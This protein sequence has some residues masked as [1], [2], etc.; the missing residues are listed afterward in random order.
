LPAGD[1]ADA[2]VI[3]TDDPWAAVAVRTAD[4]VPLLLSDARTGM[5]AAAHAGWKGLVLRVPAVTVQTL[6]DQF[7]SRPS[8]LVA[9]IGPSIGA[10]CYEIGGEVREQFGAARFSGAELSR[11]FSAE[12][13]R[14]P[15][16]PAFTNSL[17]GRR[18]HWFLDI[19]AVA[20]DQ[21]IAE[22]V[23]PDRIHVA[24]LCTASH[25]TAFCSYRRDGSRAGRLAAAI[26]RR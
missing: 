25:A 15:L 22:G 13:R 16:N 5:V 4:C 23:S 6:C 2:D 9:A 3:V 14:L 26:R 24:E 10:C 20:R 12:P 7:G 8:D 21:L 1:S 18:G 11:W 17:T 19:W